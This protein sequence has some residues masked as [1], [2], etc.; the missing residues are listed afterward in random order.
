MC[1]CAHARISRLS[2]LLVT[3]CDVNHK[4]SRIITMANQAQS[5]AVYVGIWQTSGQSRFEFLAGVLLKCQVLSLVRSCLLQI[6]IVV[7][8]AKFS[9]IFF[10]TVCPLRFRQYRPYR[11]H[12]RTTHITVFSPT[13]RDAPYFTLLY[14]LWVISTQ[15][16]LPSDIFLKSPS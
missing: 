14:F 3:N 10:M 2:F 16:I 4:P 12:G 1:Y 5:F 9:R 8:R 15:N 7:F 6:F 13:I 11:R